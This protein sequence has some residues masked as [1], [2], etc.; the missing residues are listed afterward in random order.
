[1]E[2]VIPNDIIATRAARIG[3]LLLVARFPIFAL[4]LIF[5]LHVFFCIVH[6]NGF[7]LVRSS[8]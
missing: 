8:D 7:W 2:K 3:C 6:F 1:M 4:V 5:C